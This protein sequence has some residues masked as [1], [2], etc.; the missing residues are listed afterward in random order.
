MNETLRRELL[1]LAGIDHEV[2][3]ELAADGSLFDGYH[4]RMEEVHRRN[5]RRLRELIAAH[6]WPGARLVGADGSEAAWR[7]VQHAIG[8]PSFQRECLTLIRA[9]AAVG[10]AEPWQAAYLEDRIRVFE[11][12]AQRFGT[13]LQPGD[14][15]RLAP[16]PIEDPEHVDARRAGV[17]LGPLDELLARATP[18]PVVDADTRARRARDYEHWLRAVGWRV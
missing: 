7:I 12:R 11:G 17:G 3:A 9:A 15:G 13:Q 10:E 4:P 6:G 2:H 5:A 14:D 18:D 16:A 1:A 8:E